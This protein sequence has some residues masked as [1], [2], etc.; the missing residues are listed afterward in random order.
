MGLMLDLQPSLGRALVVGGGAVASRKVRTL[1]EAE[2]EITVVAPEVADAIRLSPHSAIHLREWVES[3][4]DGHGLVF[5]C[6]DD[7]DV[8]R[9][10]GEAARRRGLPVLV[11]DAQ[12]EST[13]FSPAILRE[14]DMQ[15]AVSTAGA[16]PHLAKEIRSRIA[17]ALGSGWAR[18]THVARMERQSR[19]EQNVQREAVIR[20]VPQH[21]E[22]DE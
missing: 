13:F 20:S 2:F 12:R 10:V 15:V 1:A 19:R 4:L 6:T 9:A 22:D 8:N 16:S 21:R 3:D 11:A 7:R 14:G 5:A 17:E 18:V